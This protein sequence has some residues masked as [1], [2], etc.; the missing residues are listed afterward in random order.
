MD[1]V[2]LAIV[3][4]GNCANSL[5]QGLH[6]YG[7]NEP[8]AVGLV[9]PNVGPYRV[10]D[11]EVVAAFDVIEGKVGR[12]LHEAMWA[13]PN[14]THV[15]TET[16][17]GGVEVLRG[18]TLD[19]LGIYPRRVVTESSAPPV[20]VAAELRRTRA[21][22]VVNYLPVGS[23]A[24]AEYYATAALGADCAFVNCM[25]VF[26]ASDHRWA[27]KFQAARLPIVGDDVKSQVGAT[28]VHRVLAGLMRDRGVRLERTYQLNVGGN[29]DFLNMIERERLASKKQ[30]KTE[31]VVS[32][33]GINF[34]DRDIHVGPSDYVEWLGDKKIAFIRLEGS[35][36]GG[37]PMNIELRLEVWDSPNSAGIVIDAVRCA[38]LAMDR[39]ECGVVE[40][41]SSAFMKRPPRQVDDS[42]ALSEL[43]E[44]LR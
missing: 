41:P 1:K 39:G 36:F 4:V 44:W 40:E 38:K 30:S 17:R 9:R 20:D 27:A 14:G 6:H 26:L 11:V 33:S 34:E 28:I 22:V 29:N 23:Q 8:P 5:V 24:A 12:P 3:G 32:V 31:S 35:G 43:E 16:T 10:A 2:R 15:F 13:P 18:P 7:G 37:A 21:E 42:V 19:G 25:P